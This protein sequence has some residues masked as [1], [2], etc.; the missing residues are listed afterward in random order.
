MYR[1]SRDWL[2]MPLIENNKVSYFIHI[3][4][5]EIFLLSCMRTVIELFAAVFVITVQLVVISDS[6]ILL[7]VTLITVPPVQLVRREFCSCWT[8]AWILFSKQRLYIQYLKLLTVCSRVYFRVFV[9]FVVT[10]TCITVQI[11]FRWCIVNVVSSCYPVNI[12]YCV[13]LNAD[14]LMASCEMQRTDCRPTVKE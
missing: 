7:L 5:V 8:V 2:I 12:F 4:F 11:V 3:L 13:C 10:V 14:W 6:V 1:P 9:L